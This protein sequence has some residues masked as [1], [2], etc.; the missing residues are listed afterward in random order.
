MKQ[1]TTSSSSLR[2]VPWKAFAE[3]QNLNPDSKIKE[4]WLSLNQEDVQWLTKNGKTRFYKKEEILLSPDIDATSVYLMIEGSAIVLT[5]N[6]FTTGINSGCIAGELSYLS[7]MRP[8]ARVIALPQS[9]IFEISIDK[10]KKLGEQK[11]VFATKLTSIFTAFSVFRLQSHL[12]FSEYYTPSRTVSENF[13]KF[14]SN[15]KPN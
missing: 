8:M 14:L 10:L 1:T 11:N 15:F 7:G 5:E 3:K 2:L 13:K 4:L 6:G 9:V 12:G